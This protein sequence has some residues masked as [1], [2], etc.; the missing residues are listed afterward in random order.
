MCGYAVDKR[1]LTALQTWSI[2][3]AY[4]G[5]A[6]LTTAAQDARDKIYSPV[7][8]RLW[9]HL[10]GWF[11]RFYSIF[12]VSFAYT[13]LLSWLASALA[14]LY[15]WQ[16]LRTQGQHRQPCPGEPVHYASLLCFGAQSTGTAV[17]STSPQVLQTPPQYLRCV[18][19]TV[20]WLLKCL[21]A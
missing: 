21:T 11:L 4:P 17:V 6:V 8:V 13:F 20:L 5:Q 3:A 7:K 9:P 16:Q 12:G 14:K 19:A 15:V 18:D 2:Q 10:P 1:G